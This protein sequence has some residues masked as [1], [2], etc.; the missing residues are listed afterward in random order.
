MEVARIAERSSGAQGFGRSPTWNYH[1]GERYW[2]AAA[3]PVEVPGC[4]YLHQDSSMSELMAQQSMRLRHRVARGALPASHHLAPRV[5]G[6]PTSFCAVSN[7]GAPPVCP[8]LDLYQTFPPPRVMI[9]VSNGTSRH[10]IEAGKRVASRGLKESSQYRTANA[11]TSCGLP[12]I[13]RGVPPQLRYQVWQ[14][15]KLV[16]SLDLFQA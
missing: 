3:T 2:P 1:Q 6:S 8:T 9:L 16:Q 13:R 14:A 10:L 15:P 11:A 4:L 12:F 5:M 7:I